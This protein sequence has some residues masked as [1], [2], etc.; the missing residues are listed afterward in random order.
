MEIAWET[1]LQGPRQ[2]RCRAKGD[3]AREEKMIENLS[4][5]AGR[6]GFVGEDDINPVVGQLGEQVADFSLVT[7]KLDRGVVLEDRAQ[8]METHQLRKRIDN[9]RVEAQ[10]AGGRGLAGGAEKLSAEGENFIGVAVDEMAEFGQDRSAAA[11]PKEIL[12][13]AGFELL[14]L[15]A[16]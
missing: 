14:D 5:A 13:E 3:I 15:R 12:P 4:T 10:G 6:S 7:G 8:N 1:S 9:S 16:D 11:A 2:P